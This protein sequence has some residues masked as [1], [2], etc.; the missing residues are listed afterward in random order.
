[1]KII[2]N[3]G[4]YKE[5]GS[6]AFGEVYLCKMLDIRKGYGFQR[7]PAPGRAVACK[8]I[9]KQRVYENPIEIKVLLSEV[10]TMK[11]VDDP[12]VLRLLHV[13]Q[14]DESFY[15]FF[16]F[17]NGGD[18]TRLFNRKGGRLREKYTLEIVRQ[19]SIALE[20]MHEKNI[21]H[22][23]LKLDN[24]LLHFPN[25][26]QDEQVSEKFLKKWKPSK[27]DV[28]VV[29]GDLGFARKIESD[30]MV[31]SHLGTPLHMSPQVLFGKNYALST[32]IWSLGTIIYQLIVGF[33]PFT[34]HDKRNLAK[35]ILRGEYKFPKSIEVSLGCLNF[36]DQCLKSKAESRIRHD[37]LLSHP[38]I[39]QDEQEVF[40]LRTSTNAAFSHPSDI[41]DLA[42]DNAVY[43]NVN[44]SSLF[45]DEMVRIVKKRNEEIIEMMDEEEAKVDLEE[46]GTILDKELQSID[47]DGSSQTDCN[48]TGTDPGNITMF[49]EL[50]KRKKK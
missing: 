15:L 39:T 26:P 7:D 50:M 6:G 43:F 40:S 20:Y 33:P 16:E 9:N 23:D 30:E 29:I 1:M 38:W 42:K 3:L 17:C 4:L 32:D 25:Q 18:L 44:D 41:G 21:V 19:L 49:Q 5:L 31:R 11:E 8:R 46:E 48:Q 14:S 2:G 36:I 47:E 34:G 10:K 28:L 24:I 13:K 12:H 27:E 37:Q 22:R 45:N 35:N